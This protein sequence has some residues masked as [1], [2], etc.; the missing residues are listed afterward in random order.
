M[1]GVQGRRPPAI[2]LS[3]TLPEITPAC[4]RSTIST[5]NTYGTVASTTS[6]SR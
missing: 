5:E 1:H 6:P 4:S 2:Q 3:Q